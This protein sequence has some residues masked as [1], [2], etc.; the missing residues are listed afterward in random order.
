[1]LLLFLPYVHLKATACIS[2]HGLTPHE[3]SSFGEERKEATSRSEVV[4]T[5][6][7]Y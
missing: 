4:Y 1:M 7:T 6:D 2:S 5:V 3:S